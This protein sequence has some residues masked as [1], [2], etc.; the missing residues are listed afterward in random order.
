M[1]F[2]MITELQINLERRETQNFYLWSSNKEEK[3]NI[4]IVKF[5]KFRT[6]WYKALG[7]EETGQSIIGLWNFTSPKTTEH[8]KTLPLWLT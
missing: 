7:R 8:Q 1:D 3:C 2:G 4:G 6:F 5:R